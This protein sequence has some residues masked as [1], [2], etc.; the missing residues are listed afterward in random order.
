MSW[1]DFRRR[2][3]IMDSAVAEAV[4]AGST[5]DGRI[6][7]DRI[8]GARDL[9]GTEEQLLLALHQRWHQILTG[10]LRA[11]GAGPED[12]TAAPGRENTEDSDQVDAVS[13]AWRRAVSLNRDLHAVVNANVERV[14]ALRLAQDAELRLLAVTSGLA[15]P[16]EPED[17]V[18]AV[19]A[20]LVALLRH[21]DV[22]GTK[23]SGGSATSGDGAIGQWPR[24]LAPSA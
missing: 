4:R 9:F 12:V 23:P 2:R 5:T 20:T 13:R 10:H 14:P 1:S 19:G 21:R 18:I 8:D 16:H 6:P 7:F 22:S 24:R 15:A 11:E 17:E 3:D